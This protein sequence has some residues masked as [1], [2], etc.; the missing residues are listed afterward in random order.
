MARQKVHRRAFSF[1]IASSEPVP[2]ACME[3][4]VIAVARH[5]EEETEEGADQGQRDNPSKVVAR[6]GHKETRETSRAR[7]GS[8]DDTVFLRTK[9]TAENW[10]ASRVLGEEFNDS[11]SEDCSEH[12]GTKG[13]PGLKT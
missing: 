1:F 3:R 12:A 13:E 5:G 8:L 2:K 11:V 7:G 6:G 4:I 10:K 9:W